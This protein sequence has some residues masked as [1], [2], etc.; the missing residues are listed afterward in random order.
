MCKEIIVDGPGLARM[1][2]ARETGRLNMPGLCAVLTRIG[3]SSK[4]LG[5]RPR[6]FCELDPTSRIA[7]EFT[8]SGFA[9]HNH[10]AGE[11]VAAIERHVGSLDKTVDE[12]VVVGFGFRLLPLIKGILHKTTSVRVYWLAVGSP[13][14]TRR[15]SISPLAAEQFFEC[16]ICFVDLCRY[17]KQIFVEHQPGEPAA[18]LRENFSELRLVLYQPDETEKQGLRK[19]LNE[20]KGSIGGKL[21]IVKEET[22][23]QFRIGIRLTGCTAAHAALAQAVQSWRRQLPKLTIKAVA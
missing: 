12:L 23:D 6:V 9:V 13:G 18:A 1:Q 14:T 19:K 3:T 8:A 15:K 22:C 21:E 11:S 5:N 4:I 20:L 16:G 10:P 2:K 7:A 17:A